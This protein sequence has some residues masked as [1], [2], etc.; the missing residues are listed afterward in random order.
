MGREGTERA[1][2]A[3]IQTTGAALPQHSQEA[4]KGDLGF[5]TVAR[6]LGECGR[7]RKVLLRK[8]NYD[9]HNRD[10]TSCLTVIHSP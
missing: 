7:R 1:G 10:D 5:M 6:S 8:L 3:Q 9:T 2:T 4:L